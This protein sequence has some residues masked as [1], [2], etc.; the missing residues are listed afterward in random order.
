VPSLVAQS[1]ALKNE[2]PLSSKLQLPNAVQ[3]AYRP[4]AMPDA[5]TQERRTTVRYQYD[6]P[7][8]LQLLRDPTLRAAAHS[9]DIGA[10]GMFIHADMRLALGEEIAITLNSKGGK[11]VGATDHRQGS[12]SGEHAGRS[13]PRGNH[14]RCAFF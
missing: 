1:A 2:R 10:G 4:G 14:D 6:F 12:K 13:R 5:A 8:A 9:R 3:H 7:V 11:N